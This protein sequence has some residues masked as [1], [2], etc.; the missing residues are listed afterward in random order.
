MNADTY[1]TVNDAIETATPAI[2]R[3]SSEVWHLAELSLEET[4]SAE[5]H[6]REL[7]DAGFTIISR[8]TSGQATAFIAEWTQGEN[9]P[10]IGFLPEYDALPGLGN[11]ATSRQEVAP[12]GNANGHG[13]GHNLLGA[14]CTGA[15]IALKTSM[16]ERGKPGTVRVYGC[17]AE[18][19]TGAKVFM[20]RD[21]Y[22]DDLDACIAWHSAP[23][24][25]AGFVRTSAIN[26]VS[27]EFF[28]KT[29]H[30]GSDPW[31]GRSALDALELFCHG[32][33]LM[34]E[35]VRPTVR[36]HYVVEAGGETPNV[37]PGYARLRMFI[38][39]ENRQGVE[40]VTEWAKQLADGAAL[41]TQTKANFAI[42]FGLYDLLPNTALVERLYEHLQAVGVPDWTEEEQAFARE[43]QRNFGAQEHGLVTQV[44]PLLPDRAEGGASDVGDVS[45]NAP[46]AIFVYPSFPLGIGLHTWP[47][48][49]CGGMSIGTKAAIGAAHVMAR[50]GMDLVTDKD[51]RD[52]AREDF[53]KRRAN[54]QYTSPLASVDISSKTSQAAAHTPKDGADEY[55]EPVDEPLA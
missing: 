5:V 35:H 43:C 28:G 21:G 1:Q 47:V 44:L 10:R 34:R 53:R 51:L 12:T 18:E 55:V 31:N 14:G 15:A 41:G 9:G 49:A 27:V 50:L 19:T 48:T 25:T 45:W 42:D 30:A 20:A 37:V 13:C 36:M 22:F 39:D 16:M 52:A 23:I 46:T 4:K 3:I 24:A 26:N 40:H 2:E 7:E 54:T 11:A 6:I 33:N 32:I 29:A 38:R 8:G 17:A